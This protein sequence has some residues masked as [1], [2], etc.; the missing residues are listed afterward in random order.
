MD[1]RNDTVMLE[2]QR[3]AR[4]TARGKS[5]QLAVTAVARELR[6]MILCYRNSSPA[7]EVNPAK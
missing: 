4:L 5:K 7:V 6:L 2:H 3:Y 1:K